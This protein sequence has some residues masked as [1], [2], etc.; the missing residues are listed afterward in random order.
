MISKELANT[1]AQTI[2]KIAATH[3]FNDYD[4]E[5]L[6]K[7]LSSIDAGG[8]GGG[9]DNYMDLDNKPKINDVVLQ[10]NMTSSSLSIPSM[11]DISGH[12]GNSGIHVTGIEKSEWNNKV[13]S[14]ITGAGELLVLVNNMDVKN[15]KVASTSNLQ[16][17]VE[18]ANSAV[19]FDALN[20]AI[21]AH[22]TFESAH[23]DIRTEISDLEFGFISSLNS[24]NASTIAHN[25]IRTLAS[26]ANSHSVDEESHVS[27]PEKEKWNDVVSDFEKHEN[28][29]T[30]VTSNEKSAWNSKVDSVNEA[31][32]VYGTDNLGEQTIYDV[33][34]F[35]QLW[36]PIVDSNGDISWSKSSSTPSTSNIK[37]TKGDTG[38]DGYTFVPDWA[39]EELVSRISASGESW[40]ATGDGFL[41]VTGLFDSGAGRLNVRINNGNHYFVVSAGGWA[42]S[43]IFPIAKNDVIQVIVTHG[44]LITLGCYYT[45]PRFI[46]PSV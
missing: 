38:D 4:I 14:V 39:N 20:S 40:I 43:R 30:H 18:K 2:V 12:T 46:S 37:G 32:K 6:R 15:P 8:Q 26:N 5:I 9:T 33:S 11:T 17:A 22:N 44:V 1:F 28:D 41:H 29:E 45:P 3:A 19:Q 35:Q 7:A 36:I 23:S 13:D 25:D 10:G 42:D 27:L 16:T 31:S 34:D 21:S 24:H